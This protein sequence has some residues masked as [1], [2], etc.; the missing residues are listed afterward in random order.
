MLID[1]NWVFPEEEEEAEHLDYY[2]GV[3][4]TLSVTSGTAELSWPSSLSSSNMSRE[5]SLLTIFFFLRLR[6]TILPRGFLLAFPLSAIAFVGW[7]CFDGWTLILWSSTDVGRLLPLSSSVLIISERGLI[8][9][10]WILGYFHQSHL[11]SCLGCSPHSPALLLPSLWWRGWW[12]C[13]PPPPAWSGQLSP[14]T[15]CCQYHDRF[16][17]RKTCSKLTFKECLQSWALERARMTDRQTFAFLERCQRK[18]RDWQEILCIPEQKCWLVR[19]NLRCFPELLNLDLGTFRVSFTRPMPLH[20]NFPPQ[21][22][23]FRVSLR[24]DITIPLLV[25]DQII[26]DFIVQVL[27]DVEVLLVVDNL[28]LVPGKQLVL[29]DPVSPG[30][31]GV[32]VHPGPPLHVF[33]A[34]STDNRPVW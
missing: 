34:V 18:N 4:Y 32:C 17:K 24:P 15:G 12:W 19:N 11:Q 25:P 21:P 30:V 5:D 27:H 7:N 23:L 6:L 14:G 29:G 26:A 8:I 9:I 2:K 28:L 33:P 16:I 31:G 13:P 22:Q 3:K 10:H 1:A 20:Q